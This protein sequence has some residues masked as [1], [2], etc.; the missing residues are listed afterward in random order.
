MLWLIL[1]KF[2]SVAKFSGSGYKWKL[3][4]Q[5]K[6]EKGTILRGLKLNILEALKLKTA[7]PKLQLKQNLWQLK[8]RIVFSGFSANNKTFQNCYR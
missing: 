2:V 5:K 7:L 1:P 4:P 3:C 6:N 8:L